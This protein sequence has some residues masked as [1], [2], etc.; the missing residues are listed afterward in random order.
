MSDYD[1]ECLLCGYQF[2]AESFCG[3]K[4]EKCPNH[5]CGA[6]ASNIVEVEQ[7]KIGRQINAREDMK[8]E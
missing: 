3:P 7:A 1:F 6:P 5:E 4:P 2:D 8:N